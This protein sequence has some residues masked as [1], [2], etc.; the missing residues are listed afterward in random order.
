LIWKSP[1]SIKTVW[2]S[3]MCWSPRKKANNIS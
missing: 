3:L 1:M 2:P